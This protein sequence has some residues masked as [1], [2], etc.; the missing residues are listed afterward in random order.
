MRDEAPGSTS[1]ANPAVRSLY[2]VPGRRG[3]S[4]RGLLSFRNRPFL[5]RC[6]NYVGPMKL[7]GSL[8]DN[9]E[10]ALASVRRLRG[11]PVYKDTLNYWAELVQE[12][13]RARQDPARSRTDEL[14]AA[15]V[16]LEI[17][18]AERAK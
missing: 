17:E 4:Q 5:T 18:L 10:G 12:A 7:H 9:L 3:Q 14:E 13:R 16:K 11:H 1:A 2:A 8:I 6:Q 15:I